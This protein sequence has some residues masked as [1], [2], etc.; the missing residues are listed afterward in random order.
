[1]LKDLMKAHKNNQK[2]FTLVE[3]MIVVA[4]IG[5]LA[6]IAVPQYLSYIQRS[7][8]TACKDNFTAAHTYVAS[9]LAKRANPGGV[10]SV[11]AIADLNSGGKKDPYGTVAAGVVVPAFATAANATA[12]SCVTVVTAQTTGTNLNTEVI[13]NTVTVTPGAAALA[14]A[15]PP[16]AVILRVE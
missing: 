13:G 11:D 5:I 8:L 9:E 12:N 16:V 2:G 14:D 4:I 6:A 7:K 15:N 1:M 3:L 10:A